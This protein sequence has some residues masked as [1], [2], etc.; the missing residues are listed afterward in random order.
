MPTAGVD[1]DP[2]T[3]MGTAHYM[4]PEHELKVDG[5]TDIFSLGVVL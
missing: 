3:V 2:G 5:H 4:S 1:T